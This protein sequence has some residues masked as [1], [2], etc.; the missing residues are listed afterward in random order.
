MKGNNQIIKALNE[1]LSEELAAISQYMVHAE[2]AANWGYGKLH[3]E[4]EKTAH[5]EMHH[6]ENLIGRIIFLEGQPVVNKLAPIKIGQNVQGIV[7]NDYQGEVSAVKAYNEVMRLAVE[8]GDN[9]TRD[10]VGKIL[11]DEEGHVD[12]G[13]EQR[14][15][16]QQ[17][18]LENYL[19]TKV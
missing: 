4:L 2:M 8:S 5:T 3:E 7:T 13:E 1:R 14:D 6:A 16:I 17:M 10:L 11:Q 9:A 19:T 15:Q 12:W 18:G